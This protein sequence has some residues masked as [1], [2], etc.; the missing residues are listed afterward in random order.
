MSPQIL[1]F[2]GGLSSHS[3]DSPSGHLWRE[4][5]AGK[6]NIFLL[7]SKWSAIW[8]QKWLYTPA[9]LRLKRLL[10][11]PYY[12]LK[13][14]SC[15]HFMTSTNF[16]KLQHRTMLKRICG[17]IIDVKDRLNELWIDEGIVK[18]KTALVTETGSITGSLCRCRWG[19]SK[20]YA[21]KPYG[22]LL[23]NNRSTFPLGWV[24]ILH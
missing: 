12:C 10:N 24:Q 5:Y 2:G 20:S 19:T 14:P 11:I 21:P 4:Y 1:H 9:V 15:I 6:A 3:V 8:W 17:P 22:T 7:G 13:P 16:L 18:L 23:Y